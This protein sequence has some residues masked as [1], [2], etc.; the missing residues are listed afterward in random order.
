M[1]D[2]KD[3]ITNSLSKVN[4]STA[5]DWLLYC[6][7][8]NAKFEVLQDK[9]LT[10]TVPLKNGVPAVGRFSLTDNDY[11]SIQS[12]EWKEKHNLLCNDSFTICLE[13]IKDVEFLDKDN[14]KVI[15]RSLVAKFENVS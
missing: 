7:E 3:Y 10:E 13:E 14:V 6:F 11:L 2:I 15:Y 12:D 8:K 1:N 5:S 9:A 4:H